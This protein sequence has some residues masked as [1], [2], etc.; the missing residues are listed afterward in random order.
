MS[1]ATDIIKERDE[2]AGI[3]AEYCESAWEDLNEVY[4]KY[5]AAL[6]TLMRESDPTDK[7]FLEHSMEGLSRFGQ[8]AEGLRLIEQAKSAFNRGRCFY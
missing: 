7:D 3:A 2:F 5:K 8:L 4:K 1:S 6:Y